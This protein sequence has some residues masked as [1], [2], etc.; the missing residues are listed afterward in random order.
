MLPL[1]REEAAQAGARAVEQ[2][3][4]EGG[5]GSTGWTNDG[6]GLSERGL[7]ESRRRERERAGREAAVDWT[8]RR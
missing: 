7:D 6:G 3:I 1:P 2:G 4:G 8:G 5:D